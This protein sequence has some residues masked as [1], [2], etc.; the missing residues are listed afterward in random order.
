MLRVAV[1]GKYPRLPAP[2]GQE[3]PRDVARAL[4]D[5]RISGEEAD[6]LSAG[7]AGWIMA[8]QRAEGADE[9]ADGLLQWDDPWTGFTK[10]G[11]RIRPRA[12]RPRVRHQDARRPPHEARVPHLLR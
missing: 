11:P 1:T 9:G 3:S 5:G 4:H 12:A 7:V 8:E 6:L 2:A 10:G